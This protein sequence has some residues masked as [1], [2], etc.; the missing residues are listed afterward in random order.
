MLLAVVLLVILLVLM[1][2]AGRVAGVQE[3]IAAALG[4]QVIRIPAEVAEVADKQ[5]AEAQV[6]LV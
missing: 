1:A 2:Q 4:I 3:S 5:L 6:V